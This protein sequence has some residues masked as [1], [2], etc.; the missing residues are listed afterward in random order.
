MQ[1]FCA[2]WQVFFC[3]MVKPGQGFTN[4]FFLYKSHAITVPKK[5]KINQV[6]FDK[7]KT[8]ERRRTSTRTAAIPS[9]VGVAVGKKNQR[10]NLSLKQHKRRASSSTHPSS[11]SNPLEGCFFLKKKPS[12]CLGARGKIFTFLEGGRENCIIGEGEEPHHQSPT[13]AGKKKKKY[14]LTRRDFQCYEHKQSSALY[15]TLTHHFP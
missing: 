15:A 5:P 9:I 4:M 12:C 3:F 8:F 14:E 10:E 1:R 2:T 6:Y 7:E 13:L 11:I